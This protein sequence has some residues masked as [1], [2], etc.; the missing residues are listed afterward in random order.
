M[1]FTTSEMSG[2]ASLVDT[3]AGR[4][5]NTEWLRNWY[6]EQSGTDKTTDQNL[7]QQN[8]QLMS[9]SGEK[10]QAKDSIG[11]LMTPSQ[12]ILCTGVNCKT[13]DEFLE[14]LKKVFSP[15]DFK[16]LEKTY[17]LFAPF[18]HDKIWLPRQIRL[19]E[20]LSEFQAEEKNTRMSE[21]L[22]QVR[23]LF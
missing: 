19:D 15:D 6:F 2:L 8:C 16:I 17:K 11:R 9:N 5:H 20:Q 1:H 23:I 14:I 18:Y 10:Y 22:D 7:C 12:R 4:P 21:K 3:V 13:L